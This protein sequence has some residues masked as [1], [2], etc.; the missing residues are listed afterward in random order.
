MLQWADYSS[1]YIQLQQWI[2][3]REAKLQQVCEQKVSKARKG[4]GDRGLAIGERMA[5]LRQTNSIV[6]DIVSFEPMI[7]KVTLR[8]E[9]LQQAAP[10]TEIT[11][12]YEVLT[13]TARELYEK[14]KVTV[15]QHQAFVD[16]GNEL[17]AWLRQAKD[18]L[19]KC[20][21]P[22]GDKEGL[23]SKLNIIKVTY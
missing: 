14:Q 23:A 17:S 1:S 3:E 12:K 19:A 16:A 9:D 18:R 11:T 21:E 7:Q 5:T 4:Q 10:A 2:N 15:E 6:Q 22:I 8:A 13:K 20:S